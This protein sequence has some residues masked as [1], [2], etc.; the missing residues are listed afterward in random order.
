M[1]FK[2]Y[3]ILTFGCKLNQSESDIIDQKLAKNFIR[4]SLKEADFVLINSCGIIQKT[5]NKIIKTIKQL[6]SKNK[7]VILTGCLV[8]ISPEIKNEV[9][10]FFEGNNSEEIEK[11][12][13]DIYNS[14]KKNFSKQICKNYSS[15]IIPI[16]TGCLGNCSYC[17][18]K[19]ARGKLKSYPKKQIIDKIKDSEAKEIQLTSQDLSIYGMDIGKPSLV[20]LVSEILEIKKDFRLKLGMMN[21]GSLRLFINDFVN[22]F[23]NEKL[24]RFIH[25]PVQSGDDAILK[26]MNRN[27]T[28]N[29]FVEI[30]QMLGSRFPDFL[31]ATDII[32]GFPTESDE[33]FQKTVDLI[34]NIKP[35][36][37][38]ITRFSKRK[39]TEAYQFKDL[40]E[41]T[42]KERSRKLNVVAKKIRI[43][44]NKKYLGK[45]VDVLVVKSG[46][47]NTK[48]ARMSNGKAVI[49]KTGKI[50]EFKRVKITDFKE[51]YLISN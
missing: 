13:L 31:I 49:L 7:E 37:V 10:Y 23:E 32:V 22:L 24:Y 35:N 27:H 36:I 14:Q 21:P 42:K 16:S 43:E 18:A 38:N 33:S 3:H 50:G 5:E 40:V 20:N 19:L 11:K 44:D 12:L 51:N 9:N 8:K 45:M 15:T 4:S 26:K 34:K 47:N 46:K 39:G 6:K 30:V 41:K 29:D 48:L 2:K 28:V 17:V 1:N 25:L